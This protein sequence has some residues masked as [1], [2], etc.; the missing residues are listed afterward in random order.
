[1]SKKC[2]HC[3]TT[4]NLMKI[5]NQYGVSKANS[6]EKCYKKQIK[7]KMTNREHTWG[8][9]IAKSKKGTTFSKEAKQNI[10]KNHWSNKENADEI[11]QKIGEKAKEMWKDD[12][13]RKKILKAVCRK[14]QKEKRLRQKCKDWFNSV[15]EISLQIDNNFRFPDILIQDL[16]LLVEYDGIH[17][18]DIEDDKERDKEILKSYSQYCILHYRSYMPKSKEELLG[19]YQYMLTLNKNTLYIES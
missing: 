5:K 2:K 10:K 3:G 18:H 16:N 4:K 15:K 6:C 11:K 13:T 12:E 14:S 8:D 1:M 19:H 9:K 17:W 7:D